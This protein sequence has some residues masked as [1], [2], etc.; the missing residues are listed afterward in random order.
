MRSELYLYDENTAAAH[1]RGRT[2]FRPVVHLKPQPSTYQDHNEDKII[3]TGKL[4]EISQ[5]SKAMNQ[6]SK[7]C[8]NEGKKKY[9]PV[10]MDIDDPEDRT[11]KPIP[12]KIYRKTHKDDDDNS[13]GMMIR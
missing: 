7:D 12:S 1:T 11:G 4:I 10:F 3:W 6:A 9:F 13:N 8:I 2:V 5:I